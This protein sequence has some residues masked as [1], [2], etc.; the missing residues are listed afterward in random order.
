MTLA[1]HIPE[2]EVRV[3]FEEVDWTASKRDQET[4]QDSADRVSPKTSEAIQ[5]KVDSKIEATAEEK[6]KNPFH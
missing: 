3:T 1:W 6:T 2:K 4:V 5:S